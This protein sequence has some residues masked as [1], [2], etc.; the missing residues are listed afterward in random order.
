MYRI[1]Q[2]HKLKHKFKEVREG[3]LLKEAQ[4]Q[5]HTRETQEME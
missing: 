5:A 1:F 4:D 3:S 2:L